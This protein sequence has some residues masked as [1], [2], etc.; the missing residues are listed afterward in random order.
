MPELLYEHAYRLSIQM[1][2]ASEL[3]SIWLVYV[4]MEGNTWSYILSI[5]KVT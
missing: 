2:A 1:N 5:R 4:G 3:F